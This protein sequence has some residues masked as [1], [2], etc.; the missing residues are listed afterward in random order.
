MNKTFYSEVFL[1]ILEQSP[2]DIKTSECLK[3]LLKVT[4]TSQS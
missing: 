4:E 2:V 1:T 3:I